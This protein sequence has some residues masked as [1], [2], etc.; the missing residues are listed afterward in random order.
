MSYSYMQPEKCDRGPPLQLPTSELRL[1]AI[2]VHPKINESP[3]YAA[4]AKLLESDIRST[5][6]FHA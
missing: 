3:P 4:R 2:W 1:S 6:N 5:T